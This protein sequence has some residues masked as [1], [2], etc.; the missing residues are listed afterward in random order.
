MNMLSVGYSNNKTITFSDRTPVKSV[1]DT[2][3]AKSEKKEKL[4][5]SA[6]KLYT[7]IAALASLSIA[8]I[9]IA[10]SRKV[11]QTLTHNTAASNISNVIKPPTFPFI[12]PYTVDYTPPDTSK[13][14]INKIIPFDENDENNKRKFLS[15]VRNKV[16]ELYNKCL[17]DEAYV[18]E[19]QERIVNIID[20]PINPDAPITPDF[21]R[22]KDANARKSILNLLRD[23]STIN[24][25]LSAGGNPTDIEEV[26]VIDK[27]IN[28][29]E[30]LN[31]D[32]TVYGVLYTEKA[33]DG[34]KPFDFAKD[35]LNGDILNDPSYMI[36]SRGY[37][38]YL[39]AADPYNFGKEHKHS[40]CILRMILPKGT[41]GLD[42]RRLS[43]TDNINGIN[44]LFVLPRNSSVALLRYNCGDKIID[45][46]YLLP[47]V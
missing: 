5:S 18:P 40:G 14:I 44:A 33:W 31:E 2:V 9:A 19:F 1:Q 20:K 6:V 27:I 16:T 32:T 30:P 26:K 37:G 29:A 21:R 22:I 17:N 36:M 39:R 24:A 45:C 25:K 11:T 12:K 4:S 43:G 38:D 46:K 8:G 3:P 7:G 23:D 28:E 34:N 42:L 13:K 35:I 10:R 15:E 41:K 47:S